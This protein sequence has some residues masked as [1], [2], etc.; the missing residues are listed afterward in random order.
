MKQAPALRRAGE[1]QAHRDTVSETVP[2]MTKFLTDLLGTKLVAYITDTDAGT[3]RRWERDSNGPRDEHERRL[4]TTAF[5]ARLLLEAGDADHVVRAWF[6]GCNPQLADEAP[7]D[8]I[9]DDRPRDA[10]AAARAFVGTA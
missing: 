4:R 3:V 9:R 6:I 2:D 10:V 1:H 8:V 5:V 7:A